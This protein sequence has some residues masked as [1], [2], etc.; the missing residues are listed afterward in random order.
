MEADNADALYSLPRIMQSH[1]HIAPRVSETA[2]HT[3]LSP[4]APPPLP[5][6]YVEIEAR[7]K[8]SRTIFSEARIKQKYS[9]TPEQFQ[10]LSVQTFE[11][12]STPC[13]SRWTAAPPLHLPTLHPGR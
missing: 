10:F 11:A 3:M 4:L 2:I 1:G 5:G 13:A 6:E 7:S 12:P 8:L 9:M